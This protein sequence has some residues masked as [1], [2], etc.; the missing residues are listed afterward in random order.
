MQWLVIILVLPYFFLLLRVYRGLKKLKTYKP[1]NNGNQFVSVIIACRNEQEHLPCILNNLREQIYPSELFEVII[2]DDNSTDS[3]FRIASSFCEIKNISVLKNNGRGKKAALITAVNAAKG[4]LIVTTDADC[5]M[6]KEWLHTISS[7]SHASGTDMIVC[8]VMV[9]ESKGVFGRFAELEFLGLQGVTAGTLAQGSGIM[10]NGANLAFRKE[11]FLSNINNLHPEIASG[12][13][14][15]LLHSLKKKR[16]S[17]IEWME[18]M[19]AAVITASPLSTG[20][21]FK[22]RGRWISKAPAYKDINTII[23]G[24]VT[25]VT[26]LLLIVSP[27][28]ALFDITFIYIYIVALI[29]KSIPDYL[30]LDR[31]TTRYG[32]KK[33]MSW[34]IP[35]Q[36]IYPL[37]VLISVCYGFLLPRSWN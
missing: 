7:F 2:V 13:D 35:S 9:A 14:V 26:I 3:T 32:K 22:Q 17:K 27:A 31:T 16:G 23:M 1:E 24:I 5:I 15:F 11:T 6:Q 4:S 34:F 8:P 18:A 36:V 19:E 30:I 25:F 20:K 29:I 28:I 37:Y 33:L 21:F 12:D 10:C